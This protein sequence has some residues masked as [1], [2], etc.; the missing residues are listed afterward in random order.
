MVRHEGEKMAKSVGN[1]VMVRD[2]L[3]DWSPD[4][5]RLYLAGYHYRE[6][7]SYD[8]EGLDRAERLARKLRVAVM[9]EGGGGAFLS[10]APTRSAFREAMDA[11]LR[12]PV[13]LKALERLADDI[14]LA[15]GAGQDVQG[16]Q[17]DLRVMSRVFGLRL[18]STEPEPRVAREWGRYLGD[19]SG[20]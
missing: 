4:A 8:A 18:D 13:A 2:L 14:L 20:V 3:E 17:E 1:L 7:W 19:F 9:G 6:S 12:T 5:L 16:A 11:D 10:P 15:A